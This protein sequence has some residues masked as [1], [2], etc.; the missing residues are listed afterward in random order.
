[1]SMSTRV[2]GFRPADET[3]TQMKN[4]WDTCKVA[5]V[6]PPERVLAF[7]QGDYPGDKPGMEVDIEAALTE[8]SAGTQS[9]FELDITKLPPSVNI[10]RFYNSW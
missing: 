4:I 8:W 1:M 5:G 6:E 10:L 3:W 2:V 9:G 7:F